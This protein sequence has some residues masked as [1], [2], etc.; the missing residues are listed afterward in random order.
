[1]SAKAK[2][3][4]ARYGRNLD[5][6]A[7]EIAEQILEENYHITGFFHPEQLIV[8]SGKELQEFRWGLIPFWA[9]N[10]Q[11]AEKI[12]KGTVNARS[13]TIF[14]K[15]SFRSPI[16]HHRC[17]IP[18]TGYY[19]YHENE[20][21]TKVPYYIY[22]K[23]QEIFSFAGIYDSWLNPDTGKE[24]K[25]FSMIIGEPNELTRWIHNSGKNPFRMPVIIPEGLE[26]KWL[27]PKLTK[28]QIKEF[29]KP[30]PADEMEAYE[31]KKDAFQSYNPKDSDI[32][33]KVK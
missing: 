5:L 8:T 26:E 17:L 20:D 16:M 31:V 7:V 27:D 24:E 30:Y 25:T 13:E 22:L 3:L 23:D 10:R 9:K 29:F 33:D 32:Q 28:E 11:S 1:M 12:S 14:E 15:P 6:S 2:K 19:E 18:S 4:A 21:G